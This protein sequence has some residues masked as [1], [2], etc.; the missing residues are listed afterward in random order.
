MSS[1]LLLPNGALDGSNSPTSTIQ[2]A[3][4]PEEEEAFDPIISKAPDLCFLKSKT[5]VLR[6]YSSIVSFPEEG[7]VVWIL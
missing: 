4:E 3:E 6:L 1:R 2:D 5:S 7:Q